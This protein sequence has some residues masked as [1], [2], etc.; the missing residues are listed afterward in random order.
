[1]ETSNSKTSNSEM[2][3]WSTELSALSY[4][5]NRAGAEIARELQA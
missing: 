1:M 5:L 3:T 4:D 2:K